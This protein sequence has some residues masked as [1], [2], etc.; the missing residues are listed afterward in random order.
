VLATNR[1]QKTLT[2]RT[3]EGPEQGRST[4]RRP[5]RGMGGEHSVGRRGHDRGGALSFARITPACFDHHVEAPAPQKGI[6]RGHSIRPPKHQTVPRDALLRATRPRWRAPGQ[7]SAEQGKRLAGHSDR[8]E[9]ADQARLPWL[10]DRWV[11]PR[12]CAW[13]AR[14][15]DQDSRL[16]ARPISAITKAHLA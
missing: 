11:P 3:K 10:P 12:P 16:S 1:L 2:N 8:S 7:G 15:D 14:S 5:L 4:I 13:F 9:P 6:A